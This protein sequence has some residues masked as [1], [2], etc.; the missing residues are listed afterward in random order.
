MG[1][2]HKLR[3]LSA[4]ESSINIANILIDAVFNARLPMKS[5]QRLI[6]GGFAL[7]IL[8]LAGILQ[9]ASAFSA[10]FHPA[11]SGASTNLAGTNASFSSGL[12][13]R[14]T[15][16]NI[17]EIGLVRLDGSLRTIS[18]PARVRLRDE[19]VEYALVTEEGKGYESIFTTAA[20]PAD[21]HV[22]ALLLGLGEVP[23]TGD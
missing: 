21:I 22:A 16:S 14:Q 1:S 20:R 8:A 17:F 13:I 12:I 2:F 10:A 3:T 15:G 4:R 23:V 7:H 5:S 18:L 9:A 11:A 19:V 6:N